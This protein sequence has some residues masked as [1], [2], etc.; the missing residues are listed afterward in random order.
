MFPDRLT[1]IGPSAFKNCESI[2]QVTIPGSVVEIGNYAFNNC[3]AL[4]TIFLNDYSLE[5]PV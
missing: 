4:E 2:T 1:T 5:P 3:Y